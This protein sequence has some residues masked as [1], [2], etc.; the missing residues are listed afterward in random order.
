MAKKKLHLNSLISAMGGLRSEGLIAAPS[1]LIAC[2]HNL[3]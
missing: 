3:L 2:L 1:F